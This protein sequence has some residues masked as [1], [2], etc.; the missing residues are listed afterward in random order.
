MKKSISKR[1]IA[2]QHGIFQHFQVNTTDYATR[3]RYL[4]MRGGDKAP[5]RDTE[6]L[7]NLND[8]GGESNVPTEYVAP[9]LSTRYSPDRVGVQAQRIGDGV[10]QDPYTN[11]VYDYN[12]GF[13]T[14]D[15]R[16]FPGG[17][18]S[19]Q[20]SMMR[21]ANALD[22]KGFSKYAN[23]VD[24]ILTKI[25]SS[26]VPKD[27]ENPLR[28]LITGGR[29]EGGRGLAQDI[30]EDGVF[31]IEL[32]SPMYES[33]R[34]FATRDELKTED[35][36]PISDEEFALMQGGSEEL[37][38]D[39]LHDMSVQDIIAVL[40]EE[41]LDV[42]SPFQLTPDRVK[43]ISKENLTSDEKDILT[44][45]KLSKVSAR[46]IT[47]SMVAISNRLD[48]AG[49]HKASENMDIITKEFYQDSNSKAEIVSLASRLD[50][51][52]NVL[53]ADILDGWLK[54]N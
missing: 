37:G 19:L 9:H 12:E 36:L 54:E 51:A 5:G 38:S 7:Y 29:F 49:L 43:E 3:E 4:S 31:G 21:L 8:L 6:S 52:G 1:A 20:S 11:K 53:V 48:N 22:Q 24:N 10:Y 46:A 33:S 15:G 30:Y 16:T 13:Q 18:A 27:L 40:L 14:E 41:H 32:D 39:D 44:A 47:K 26:F 35:G 50:E 34:G 2:D 23:E 25:G 45:Q 28:V 42:T 17:A